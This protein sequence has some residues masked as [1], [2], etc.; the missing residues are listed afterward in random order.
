MPAEKTL[1]FQFVM[2]QTSFNSVKGA[3]DELIKRA[4]TLADT[5]KGVNMPGTGGGGG[6]GI[7]SGGGVGGP[8]PAASGG[9]G[10][11]S[12]TITAALSES[13]ESFKRLATEGGRAMTNLTSGMRQGVGE[14]VRQ[15]R[16]LQKELK[17]LQKSA[18]EGWGAQA[19]LS[20]VRGRISDKVSGIRE[21]IDT[22]HALEGGGSRGLRGIAGAA[23]GGVRRGGPLLPD[24]PYPEGGNRFRDMFQTRLGHLQ[25][26][27]QGFIDRITGGAGWTG[28]LGGTGALTP[29]GVAQWAMGGSAGALALRLGGIGLAG[30]AAV[31]KMG[32]TVNNAMM[33]QMSARGTAV[34]EAW[35]KTKR[36]DI[37][38]AMVR[39]T[40]GKM[41]PE[42]RKEIMLAMSS[43]E[44]DILRLG[45]NAW[46]AIKTGNLARLGVSQE[47]TQKYQAQQLI[48]SKVAES[49]AHY[50]DR[51][52]ALEFANESRGQ[53]L[54]A[55]R[56][57]GLRDDPTATDP[58]KR[59]AWSNWAG[60]LMA[61]NWT[62][63]ESMAAMVQTRG[64]GGREFSRHFAGTV[65]SANAGG[66]GGVQESLLAA[67]YGGG[68]KQAR[69]LVQSALGGGIDTTAGLQLAQSIF[70]YD[71]RGV[72]SGA[73][74]LSAIQ[75]GYG[76]TGG[77]DDMARVRQIQGGLGAGERL[78][79]G[80]DPYQQGRNIMAAIGAM[81]G[82]S[83][84]AQ[85]SLARTSF[86]ELL[87]LGAG[88]NTARSRAYGYGQ[89]EAMGQL[90]GM[91]SG[92][93]DRWVDQGGDS[94]LDR[95]MRGMQESGVSEL[96]YMAELGK[97]AKGKGKDAKAA[98]GELEA[99]GIYTSDEM[100][101][102]A[103]EGMGL[104]ALGSGIKDLG[105]RALKK[106]KIPGA[107]KVD[108]ETEA[109]A[110]ADAEQ[111]K[112]SAQKF[113]EHLADMVASLGKN[114][115]AA[116]ILTDFSQNLAGSAD[117]AAG[118]LLRLSG[119]SEATI[120]ALGGS[121][122]K[123]AIEQKVHKTDPVV[124]AVLRGGSIP[125]Q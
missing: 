13:A 24:L 91:F 121:T 53:R 107:G 92:V 1:K 73:G 68:I 55:A 29:Q 33:E 31:L 60:K 70:G 99:L 115:D 116:K 119:A 65:M 14:Q 59:L 64:A 94:P 84:Y 74:V 5:L 125:V 77:A 113:N 106:G 2:D 100:G 81:P 83:T 76:F 88:G 98:R 28:P 46:E 89:K 67:T 27:Q 69:G 103:E 47:E 78:A 32:G 96:D 51:G 54:Q 112:L 6:S 56:V 75:G 8:A 19:A 80:F 72:V 40:I 12:N 95:A 4:K 48:L 9:G 44:Q 124:E 63:E 61:G 15:L 18:G 23:L 90:G 45:G 26:P 118:S 38:D 82:S 86:K 111:F 79:A 35:E 11:R 109:K 110:K 102:G 50:T 105:S 16:A 22:I 20:G 85:D 43:K 41:D 10:S 58:T 3:L 87:E 34:R 117:K 42:S 17:D 62:Q 49:G 30:G 71:P 93:F 108:T 39:R 101:V 114:K 66:W 37:S 36:A 122:L 97:R 104:V 123:E 57:M 21:S 52:R 7:L 25:T 120:E